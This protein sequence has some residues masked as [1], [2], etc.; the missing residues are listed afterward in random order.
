MKLAST[1]EI[2]FVASFRGSP[3]HSQRAIMTAIIFM[4]RVAGV[5]V[6]VFRMMILLLLVVSGGLFSGKLLEAGHNNGDLN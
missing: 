4:W 6:N 3:V 1:R 5:Q 2:N